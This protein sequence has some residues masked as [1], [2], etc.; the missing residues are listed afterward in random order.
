M[1]PP[2]DLGSPDPAEV[3][4][5]GYD[6]MSY[7]YRAD[8]AGSGQ[9]APWLSELAGRLP[10]RASVL[11]IGCGC[12]VPVSRDLARRSY[13]VVGVDLSDV[14]IQRAR[15]LVPQAQFVRA[16]V[17]Q[18]QF[19]DDT[20]DAVLAFY[21]VIHLPLDRQP[22]LFADIRRWLRPGGWFVATLGWREWTGSEPQW[23]GGDATMW[24][25]HAD[26]ATYRRWLTDV[27]LVVESVQ[28]VPEG[29]GG[30]SLFWAH[31]SSSG[32]VGADRELGSTR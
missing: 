7:L 14:Q 15:R 5:T 22:P 16:D 6:S 29:E 17:T 23:L 26:V 10:A 13:R 24:W 21:S 20:F 8:D 3:V 30:H 2:A 27:G 25:S 9:Y 31:R 28:F 18:V 4:R 1:T 11:D 19:A 32:S 12:G